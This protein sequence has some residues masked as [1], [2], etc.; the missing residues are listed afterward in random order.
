MS[1]RDIFKIC[2]THIKVFTYI[3]QIIQ[4]Y[5]NPLQMSPIG[6]DPSKDALTYNER[7][8]KLKQFQQNANVIFS[9]E[10][11][12]RYDYLIFYLGSIKNLLVQLILL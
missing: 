5:L 2:P 6:Y 1:S 10:L 4:R 8:L 3:T 11:A 12:H 7:F 9:H